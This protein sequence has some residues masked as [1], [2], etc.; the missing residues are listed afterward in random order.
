ML[1]TVSFVTLLATL[2]FVYSA[3]ALFCRCCKTCM[4]WVVV[5]M[6]LPAAVV[7]DATLWMYRRGFFKYIATFALGCAFIVPPVWAYAPDQAITS[8]DNMRDRRGFFHLNLAQSLVGRD[9]VWFVV[10]GVRWFRRNIRRA[11]TVF[12]WQM[13]VLEGIEKALLF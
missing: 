12:E 5:L 1:G 9:A 11:V 10:S 13:W 3:V 4:L 7:I 6:L 8:T 2:Q